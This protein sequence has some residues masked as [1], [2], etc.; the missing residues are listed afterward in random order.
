MKVRQAVALLLSHDLHDIARRLAEVERGL[1]V[2]QEWVEEGLEKLT[3][4]GS[5][6]LL[7]EAQDAIVES[8]ARLIEIRADLTGRRPD[9]L[10]R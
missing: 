5:H 3:E 9:V 10:L 1:V 2:A 6:G 8:R 7:S 4:P